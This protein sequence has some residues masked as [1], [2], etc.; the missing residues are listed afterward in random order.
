MEANELFDKNTKLAYKLANLIYAK[1]PRLEYEDVCQE[2]LLGLW[3]AATKFDEN[4]GYNFS[5]FAYKVIFRDLL[6]YLRKYYRVTGG[7]S[8]CSLDAELDNSIGLVLADTIEGP[9]LMAD[10]EFQNLFDEVMKKYQASRKSNRTDKQKDISVLNRYFIEGIN[11]VEIGEE[12]NVS[13]AAISK[14]V[15]NFTEWFKQNYNKDLI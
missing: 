5:T 8:V 9:N 12:D 13:R 4:A 6:V 3:K 2:A 10:Y 15:C 1:N 14:R 11:Q 7:N